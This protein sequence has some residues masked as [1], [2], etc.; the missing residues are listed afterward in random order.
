MKITAVLPIR[1]G[2]KSITDKNIRSFVG[3]PLFHWQLMALLSCKKIDEVWVL[4]DYDL[5][6]LA[7]NIKHDKLYFFERSPEVS[8]DESS[9][10]ETVLEFLETV[11]TDVLIIAQATNPFV[12]SK[13]YEKAIYQFINNHCSSLLSVSKTKRFYWD[14]T[15]NP[16]NY[17]FH[18]RPRRQDFESNRIY[19]ENGAFYIVKGTMFKNFQNRIVRPVELYVMPEYTS[20]EIDEPED[21]ELAERIFKEK[22]I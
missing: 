10:E 12:T 2:S 1:K 6:H 15:G 16:I 21:W 11:S 19:V 7:F 9:T 13:D 8:K 20:L 18:D 5:N 3:R 14:C 17:D 22:H 4:T